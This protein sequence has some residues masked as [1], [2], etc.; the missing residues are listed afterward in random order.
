[1]SA[2]HLTA[3]RPRWCTAPTTDAIVTATTMP[4]TS[5]ARR[6]TRTTACTSTTPATV[7][8]TRR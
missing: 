1:M 2:A 3:C 6:G 8:V 5:R 7:V 4:C